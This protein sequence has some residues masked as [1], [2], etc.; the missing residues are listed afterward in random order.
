MYLCVCY[1]APSSSTVNTGTCPYDTLQNDIVDAQNAGGCI[2]VCGDVNARTAEQD[3]YTRLADLQHFVDVPEEEAYLGADVPRRSN[4]DKAPTSGTW[5]EELLELCRSTELLIVNGRTP[6]DHTGRYTFTSPQGQSVVD[7][8]L[9]SAQHLSS[10]ADMRVM[11]DAKYCNLSR[12]MPYDSEKSDHFPLQLDLSCSISTP[13]A[14]AG[15]TPS[16]FSARPQFKYVESQADAY[17]QCLT[18]ELLMHLVPLLTGAVDVDKVIAILVKCMVQ[19]AEQ[20]LPGKRKRSGNNT[21][22]WNPWFDAECKAA[23]KVK[24]RVLHSDASEHEKKLAVQQFQSVTARV[25][26]RWLERRSDE[27]C[28]MASKDPKGFWRAFKTQQSNVCPVELAAQFEAFRALMGSQPAQIPEQADLLGTSVRAADASCLNAPITADE[29]HDCIK[30]LKRNK[31]PGIDGVLSEMIKDGGDV[32]H[33]CLLVIFN[34]MLTNHFPK[35]LSVGLI[36][37]GLQIRRQR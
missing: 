31:S 16:Q 2:I 3:D 35:Q 30:H 22:P 32:L 4:C 24:N 10:V 27:L 14:A 25:K 28:E 34:L 18:A 13:G 12:D 20:T 7:Y 5:G 21:F 8:F 9:V 36:T 1:M 23:K 19:A 17:Q 26:G 37:A 6:G 29:L 11:C 33:N 15:S